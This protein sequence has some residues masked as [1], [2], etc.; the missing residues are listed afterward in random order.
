MYSKK[1]EDEEYYEKLMTSEDFKG[2]SLMKIITHNEFESLM[3]EADPKAENLLMTIWRGKQAARCDG[4]I[5]GYSNFTHILLTKAKRAK[6][7]T[8]F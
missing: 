6:D 5:I 1:I 3:E 4:D 8:F 7:A 2:R